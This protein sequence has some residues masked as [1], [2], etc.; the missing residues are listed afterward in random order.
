MTTLTPGA[1]FDEYATAGPAARRILDEIATEEDRSAALEIGP[2]GRPV[3]Y[4]AM[5]AALVEQTGDLQDLQ[6]QAARHTDDGQAMPKKLID[7]LLDAATR[8]SLTIEQ[9][10]T[11]AGYF[12][13]AAEIHPTLYRNAWLGLNSQISLAHLALEG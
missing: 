5:V 3:Q 2:N 9:A 1:R 13:D 6:E 11:V 7:A 10:Q 4:D 12:L 8:L